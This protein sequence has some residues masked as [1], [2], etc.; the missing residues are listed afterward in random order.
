MKTITRHQL[1]L[2]IVFVL[3]VRVL[4]SWLY[5]AP[6]TNTLGVALQATTT[7]APTLAPAPT[8]TP[9]TPVG[10]VIPLKP[11]DRLTSLNATVKIN[12]NGQLNEKR[13]QGDLTA[14]LNTNDQI[15]QITVTGPLLGDIVAQ[16]GGSV[17]GLFTPNKVDI[18]KTPD[19][20]YVVV[21]TLFDLCIKPDAPK[22]TAALEELSPQNLMQMLTSND[23]AR[24]TLVGEETLNGVPVKH[25]IIDG[26]TFL[27][28]AQSSSDPNLRTFGE[29]LWSADNAD[30]YVSSEG[31]YP[32][33]FRGSYSGEF[34]PLKFEGDFTVQVDLT[35]VNT[36]TPVTLPSACNNPIR[37]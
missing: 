1:L 11:L 18:F 35:G 10:E 4:T 9:F 3:A 20:T 13:A 34:E 24:G 12:V 8:A 26:P 29:A 16:V 7:P 30:L 6:T 32:V 21:K 23:V 33:S 36:N 2:L 27:A 25:Y 17:V 22:A 37:P 28:A 15:S 19:G 5:D 14:Q 31:G